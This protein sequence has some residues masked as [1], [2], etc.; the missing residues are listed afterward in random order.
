MRAAR[1]GLVTAEMHVEVE[2][3]SETPMMCAFSSV[4]GGRETPF[5]PQYVWIDPLTTGVIPLRVP[6]K[7]GALAVRLR[8]ANADYRAQADVPRPHIFRIAGGLAIAA[9]IALAVVALLRPGIRSLSV[10]DRVLAGDMVHAT[11]A[12]RGAGRAQ[13]VVSDGRSIVARGT[14]SDASGSFSF[15]TSAGAATYTVALLMH[16]MAGTAQARASVRAQAL[17][18]P[19]MPASIGSLAVTPAVAVSGKPFQARYASNAQAGM[20]KLF[21]DSG[22]EWDVQPYRAGGVTAFVAP[23][24]D[25]PRHFAIHLQVRRGAFYAD[26][27]TGLVVVPATPSPSPSPRPAD[28]AIAPPPNEAS[29]ALTPR[30]IVSGSSFSVRP[31]SARAG[32]LTGMVTLQDDKGASIASTP[33]NG[34]KTV[35]FS[36]PVVTR[37]T[38]YFIVAT[39]ERAKTSQLVVTPLDVHAQ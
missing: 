25:R 17:P 16:G 30:Y 14:L 24:V 3:H 35:A 26:A 7:A 2:N 37:T 27:T 4:R 32:T 19:L 13:Y 5:G 34:S 20:V 9:V 38:R 1:R 11:F 33:A 12:L 28:L 6:W 15:P 21:D 18:Q 36:A 23:H 8:G 31:Q 10:P 39:V 22:V 29:I